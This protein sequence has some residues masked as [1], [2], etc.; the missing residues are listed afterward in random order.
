MWDTAGLE[1]AALHLVSG[2]RDAPNWLSKL[3]VLKKL[4]VDQGTSGWYFCT[5][6]V[7]LAV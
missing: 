7:Q 3:E 5:A 4:L 1:G 2:D 6:V